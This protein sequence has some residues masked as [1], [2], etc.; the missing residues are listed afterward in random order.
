MRS[1]FQCIGFWTFGYRSYRINNDNVQIFIFSKRFVRNRYYSPYIYQYHDW[2]AFPRKSGK[3]GIASIFPFFN[4]SDVDGINL[5]SMMGI[6]TTLWPLDYVWWNQPPT[7]LSKWS[8]VPG[9]NYWPH[10]I[11]FGKIVIYYQTM[12]NICI[13][14]IKAINF[15]EMVHLRGYS[16]T[17]WSWASLFTDLDNDVSRTLYITNG[18]K[19][20]YT[21]MDFF[22]IMPYRIEFNQNKTGVETAFYRSLETCGYHWRKLYLSQ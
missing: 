8:R 12:R 6:R 2:W 15:S 17:D 20:D 22:K 13:G 16:N 7:R 18:V 3:N 14:T 5:I 4:G 21:N 10:K 11:A 19:R 1:C 9:P